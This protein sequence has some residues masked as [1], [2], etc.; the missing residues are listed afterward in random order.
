MGTEAALYE[1][2]PDWKWLK[3]GMWLALVQGVLAYATANLTMLFVSTSVI[4]G[5]LAFYFSLSLQQA[6]GRAGFK[7]VWLLTLP[8]A[9][10]TFAYGARL[11]LVVLDA[12]PESLVLASVGIAFVFPMAAMMWVF[13]AISLRNF[14]LTLDLDRSASRDSLTG[15]RN[16]TSLERLTSQLPI[17]ERR[18][19]TRKTACICIDLDHFKEVNDAY[20]HEAGDRLLI[21]V[22]ERLMRHAGEN[23]KVFRIGGDEFVFWREGCNTDDLDAFLQDLLDMIQAPVLFGDIFLKVG[24]SFGFEESSEVVSPWDLI[25]RADI[26]L[27]RSKSAGRNQI[28]RYD[29]ELG[30]YHNERLV[31]L[32]EF[33]E[34]MET[35]QICVYYQPQLDLVTQR[36]VGCE[37]LARWNHPAL[38]IL[39]PSEFMPFAEELGLL[40]E[41]DSQVLDL[42][43]AAHA[44]W[45]DGGHD[46]PRISV[47]VS[48]NRL[49]DNALIETLRQRT[50]LPFG[51]LSFEVLE[52]A[53]V[54]DDP[55]I[56]WNVD[57]LREMNIGIEVDDFGTGHA[58]L[59]SVLAIR[60]DR[61]KIDR[62]F[63]IDIEND[64][65][66]REFLRALIDLSA[67]ADAATIIEGVETQD[68]MRIVRELGASEVQ[69]FAVAPPM[70]SDALMKWLDGGSGL[71]ASNR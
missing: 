66:K 51:S 68:Q 27:Y 18:R 36:I 40:A 47:N 67:R 30:R 31:A 59:S 22:A 3:I 61:I 24:A 39:P 35:E 5:S 64:L 15:L 26:A 44:A 41:L 60:P 71:L 17:L 50:D 33:R 38:G 52:T 2:T 43:V 70:S 23:D 55:M 16:R 32:K 49:R 6:A 56:I 62:K 21:A 37:A 12:A 13:G 19:S 63:V 1:R 45:R 48:A 14:H 46:I 9:A 29:A 53:L 28:T 8:F 69:G 58:S 4:N 7:A 54:E 20:G 42:A 57:N 25:R 11:V 10:I 34:A 65:S